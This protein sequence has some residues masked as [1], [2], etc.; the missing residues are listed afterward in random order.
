MLQPPLAL[1]LSVPNDCSATGAPITSSLS[2]KGRRLQAPPSTFRC[3]IEILT[4]KFYVY[5]HKKVLEKMDGAMVMSRC[6]QEFQNLALISALWLTLVIAMLIEFVGWGEY[7]SLDVNEADKF[8]NPHYLT[9]CL[10]L[11]LSS[12]CCVLAVVFATINLIILNLITPDEVRTYMDRAHLALRLPLG[13]LVLGIL[14]WI[15]GMCAFLFVLLTFTYGLVITVSIG[16]CTA[17]VFFVWALMLQAAYVACQCAEL[18]Q[19]GCSRIPSRPSSFRQG[20]DATEWVEVQDAVDKLLCQAST[21]DT[22]IDAVSSAAP[23]QTALNELLQQPTP[24]KVPTTGQEGLEVAASITSELL[25]DFDAPPSAQIDF[26]QPT[27]GKG[28]VFKLIES[29]ILTPPLNDKAPGD[30]SSLP[31]HHGITCTASHAPAKEG[32]QAEAYQLQQSNCQTSAE[33]FLHKLVPIDV[34]MRSPGELVI[35]FMRQER[36]GRVWHDM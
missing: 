13:C 14:F 10:S 4:A 17:F 29:S 27:A 5:H 31:V 1:R 34:S 33:D 8:L 2:S 24:D 16:C 35:R 6:Q 22:K 7:F 28:G 20:E 11:V 12:M 9:L 15:V 26:P 25:W 3:F 21:I 36:Q 19:L 32:C 23:K 18:Q 30:T